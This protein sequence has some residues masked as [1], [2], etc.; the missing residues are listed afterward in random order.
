MGADADFKLCRVMK[1]SIGNKAVP[2][3]VTHDGRTIRYPDPDIKTGDTIKYNLAEHKIIGCYKFQMGHVAMATGGHN[4]GR[5]GVIQ[6]VEKHPGSFDI[7][8][9][10]DDRGHSFAT[11]K[12]N[13]F[14][15][16]D[17]NAMLAKR[18]AAH[19]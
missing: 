12:G 8:H 10:K 13:V 9:I 17:R 19:R 2:Y 4:M 11:R 15:L 16:E 5:V 6:K 14:I 18:A 7:I 1:R 3:I